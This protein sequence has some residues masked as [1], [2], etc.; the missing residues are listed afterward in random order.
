MAAD[1]AITYM[2]DFFQI[3]LGGFEE[4]LLTVLFYTV[5][6]VIYGILIWYFYR[7]LSKRDIFELKGG[8]KK[9]KEISPGLYIFGYL[10]VFPIFT[11]IWFILITMFL[12]FLAKAQALETILVVSI[13][14]VSAVRTAAYFNE[15]LSKD[16]A[17]MIPFALLGIFIVDPSFFSMELVKERALALPTFLPII[18]RY[19]LFVY[20]IEIIL[21]SMH[22]IREKLKHVE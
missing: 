18:L 13:T 7:Q 8:Q 15:D 14:I 5:G 12:I 11:F 2:T 22:G 20:V 1:I 9:L 21:R 3:I 16:L 10:F 17:K 4:Q 6:M 19:L